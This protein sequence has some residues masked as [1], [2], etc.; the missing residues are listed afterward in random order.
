[1][2][3]AP[4]LPGRALIAVVACLAVLTGCAADPPP[5]PQPTR[6]APTPTATGVDSDYRADYAAL[7]GVNIYSLVLSG[8]AEPADLGEPAS[9]YEFLASRGIRAIRLAVPW[10]SLQP[11]PEGGDAAAGLEAPIDEEYLDAVTRQVDRAADAGIVTVLDLHNGCTYPW[12][13]GPAIEGSLRCGD[14]IEQRHID[15]VWGALATRFRDEPAVVA[16]DI[17]NEP[18]WSVGIDAYKLFSQ[19]AVDAIRSAGARQPVW[20]EGFLSAER[21]RLAAIAPDGPWIL[22]ALDRVVY[23]EHFYASTGIDF[24][25]SAPFDQSADYDEIFAQLA[26]FGEWC[27]TWEVHCSV[28]E[29]GWPSGGDGGAQ[30]AAD[31]EAWNA[32]FDR[33]YAEADAFGL[34]IFYFAAASRQVGTLLAYVASGDNGIDRALSQADVIEAYPTRAFE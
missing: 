27:R 33:F 14:G 5:S 24:D 13:A 4:S 34:D 6:V 23:S 10:Q 1:M 12:G 25:S 2:T 29:V 31:A 21:G 32:L 3:P 7:R 19:H 18:R 22:D 26:T 16:Y 20:V 17:F 15:K 9:S 30:S 11:I 8:G 28:G